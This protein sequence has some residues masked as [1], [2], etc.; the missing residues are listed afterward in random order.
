[1]TPAA[2]RR[3]KINVPV[4]SMGDI[5]FLLII[6]FM[7]CSNFAQD[8]HVKLTP[9]E[10][11]SI[12]IMEES[13]IS[14][15]IDENDLI[16]VQGQPVGSADSVEAIVA[17][18]L[19]ARAADASRLVLFKCDRDADKSV[20]EPVLDAISRAGGIIAAVGERVEENIGPT[21][22]GAPGRK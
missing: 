9:P 12:E 19:E 6:F 8:A 22:P 20:F 4:A 2:R 15:S 11:L 10:S 14:V 16:Y 17:A 3:R 7:I 13:N 18:L 1:M 21:P 5:A